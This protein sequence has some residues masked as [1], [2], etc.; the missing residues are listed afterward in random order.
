MLNI[1]TFDVED[2]PQSTLDSGLAITNRVD[3]NTRRI[4]DMLATAGVHATFFVLGLVAARFPALV[5]RIAD[6]GHEVATHGQSHRAVY[7][8]TPEEFRSDLRQSVGLVE[9]A[10]GARVVGFRAPDF[11]IPRSAFWALEIL[12]QEGLQYDSSLYP[13]RGPR[14]GVADAFRA[15]FRVRCRA[16]PDLVEFP[17]MTI[18][19][20][21]LRWPAAGGGYFRLFPYA[22]S[23]TAI[24]RLNREPQPATAYFHPYEIDPGEITGSPHHISWGVRLSQ[25]LGRG[26]V[27]RK[28]ERFLREY[29]WGTARQRL[30]E[31]HAITQGRV[32]DL[33]D[34]PHG[35]HRWLTGETRK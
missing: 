7:T 27:R 24:E 25:G 5:R 34:L 31:R 4:L 23:R 35:P 10:A 3:D 30:E 22:Y 2:W 28:L 16:N 18:E 6:E 8:M 26:T 21:R 32:L 17:L 33:T 11:S 13:F 20:L 15:P 12:A 29:T 9:D 19:W 14:Y 1:L